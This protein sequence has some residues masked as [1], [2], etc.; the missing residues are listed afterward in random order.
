MRMPLAS[1]LAFAAI[2]AA[3][4]LP[5]AAEAKPITPEIFV[6]KNC[7]QCHQVSAYG[8]EGGETGPDLSIA[9]TDVQDRFGVTLDKFMKSPTG[10]M[11]VVLGSMVKLSPAE[12]DGI[13]KLLK[14]AHQKKAT[15]KK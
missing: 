8:I 7:T 11:Q 6:E 9:W 10:T 12:R 1:R 14:E 13:V 2:A 5:N 15:K 4:M 3:L